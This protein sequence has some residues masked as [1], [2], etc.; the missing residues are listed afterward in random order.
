[1]R[2]GEQLSGRAHLSRRTGGSESGETASRI[3]IGSLIA[4]YTANVELGACRKANDNYCRVRGIFVVKI[5]K[6]SIPK[7][8]SESP[9]GLTRE[10][11]P[12]SRDTVLGSTSN[13]EEMNHSPKSINLTN[14]RYPNLWSTYEYDETNKLIRTNSKWSWF[15]N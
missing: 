13:T 11:F 6:C 12:A 4:V 8:E 9:N 3:S 7:V 2:W 15:N 10:C 5:H 1:M 14:P